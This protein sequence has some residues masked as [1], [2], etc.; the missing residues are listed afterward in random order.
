MYF[1]TST[2]IPST[3]KKKLSDESQLDLNNS[4]ITYYYNNYNRV[5]IH[6]KHPQLT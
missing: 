2:T 4:L 1:L 5:T 3:L 6:P